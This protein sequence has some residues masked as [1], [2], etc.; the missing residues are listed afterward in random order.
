MPTHE[1]PITPLEP[2]SSC[3]RRFA[4][5]FCKPC[6]KNCGPNHAA[7]GLESLRMG[8]VHSRSRSNAGSK[9]SATR[10]I[11]ATHWLNG[12][13]FETK[14]ASNTRESIFSLRLMQTDCPTSLCVLKKTRMGRGKK[15]MVCSHEKGRIRCAPTYCC[16]INLKVVEA[17]TTV[18][19][20]CAVCAT[21]NPRIIEDCYTPFS[22]FLHL[23]TACLISRMI[24]L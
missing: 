21:K 12:A 8:R 17:K 10:K 9:A 15:I 1:P 22:R 14:R 16:M 20:G 3:I 24:F 6:W 23:L 19:A 11:T 2:S 18:G 7:A 5:A 13:A 4:V